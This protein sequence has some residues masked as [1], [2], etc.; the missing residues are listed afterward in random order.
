MTVFAFVGIVTNFI[1]VY[2][3]S[4]TGGVASRKGLV[5]SSPYPSPYSYKNFSLS[6][7]S[8]NNTWQEYAMSACKFCEDVFI[9][10]C[11]VFCSESST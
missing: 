3:F 4:P 2:L 5:S 8:S 11:S 10:L 9:D 1:G 7:M 6:S